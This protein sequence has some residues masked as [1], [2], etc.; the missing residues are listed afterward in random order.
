MSGIAF[1]RLLVQALRAPMVLRGDRGWL[2]SL[3]QRPIVFDAVSTILQLR[4]LRRLATLG[5][6]ESENDPHYEAVRSYNAGV[7][8]RK[9]ITRTRRAED[10]LAALALPPCA[11]HGERLLLIGPRNVHELLQA[12]VTGFAWRNIEAID[13]YSTNSKIRVMNMEAMT[14]ADD[15]FDAV[16]MSATLPYAKDVRGC[17]AEVMRVTK[18]GGRFVLAQTHVPE[19][20]GY[21]GNLIPGDEVI[22]W[23]AENGGELLYHHHFPRIIT[24][25]YA[26]TIHHIAVRKRLPTPELNGVPQSDSIDDA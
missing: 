26:A 19:N 7:T 5:R 15:S 2:R 9:L 25:G 3:V 12:W 8:L 1:A 16:L 10:L 14:H 4:D 22:V 21:P 23:L 6:L 24:G 17:L 13:L 18:P 11:L 20:P